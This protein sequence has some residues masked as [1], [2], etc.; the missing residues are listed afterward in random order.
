MLTA[1]Y[2][3]RIRPLKSIPNNP[4]PIGVDEFHGWI[5]WLPDLAARVPI[6]AGLLADDERNRAERY[7]FDKD[8]DR[9]ILGRGLLRS[10]LGCYLEVD[11]RQVD[12]RYSPLGKPFIADH[13]NTGRIT[14]S[15]SHSDN[16]IFLGMTREG[17][18]GVDVE[19]VRPVRENDNIFRRFASDQEKDA[20]DEL[21]DE[22]K[23][24]AFF[25]WWT[26]KEAV[27]K[28]LG[29]GMTEDASRF[30]VGVPPGEQKV[31]VFV[32]RSEGTV[33][34]FEVQRFSPAPGYDGAVAVEKKA[35]PI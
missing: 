14:F 19:R 15:V 5:A 33:C 23:L 1:K 17:N 7:Y 26:Q 31:L 28:A 3:K 6:L 16:C 10:L 20:F 8:R 12:F 32:V 11:P 4:L 24:P 35:Q 13:M 9:Y 2:M 34:E 30:S 29:D 21:D 27:V 22:E 25:R 18:I